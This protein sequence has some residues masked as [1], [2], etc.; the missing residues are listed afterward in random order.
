MNY[1][2]LSP[3]NLSHVEQVDPDLALVVNDVA[4]VMP[5][6]IVQSLRTHAEQVALVAAGKS[7]SMASM[8]LPDGRGLSRAVDVW[9]IIDGKPTSVER[10]FY[11]LADAFKAAAI[12]RSV[13]IRWGGAWRV[14]NT[15]KLPAKELA[16][17]YGQECKR[18]GQK[19][20]FDLN[21]F[22]V[23]RYG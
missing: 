19:P 15:A 12:R 4:G 3:H 8:H 5:I 2:N 22:E 23:R 14:L 9:P 6:Y 18:L 17:E 16:H 11:P 7:K 10:H 1:E 21:H 20:F 13:T